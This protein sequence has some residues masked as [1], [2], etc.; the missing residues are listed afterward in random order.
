MILV[1]PPAYFTAPII[2]T[3]DPSEECERRLHGYALSQGYEVV[4]SGGGTQA[5]PTLRFRCIFHGNKTLNTRQLEETVI[6]DEDGAILS[7]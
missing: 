7:K 6:R 5:T 3:H 1:S 2:D 4:R